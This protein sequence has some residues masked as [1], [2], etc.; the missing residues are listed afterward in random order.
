[1]F[2]LFYLWNPRKKGGKTNLNSGL[3]MYKFFSKLKRAGTS[4]SSLNAPWSPLK[5]NLKKKGRSVPPSRM[6]SGKGKFFLT[7]CTYLYIFTKM[8]SFYNLKTQLMTKT[9]FTVV[10]IHVH[11]HIFFWYE[12][13]EF[14]KK[15]FPC[16]TT[17]S[18][19]GRGGYRGRVR[20]SFHFFWHGQGQL[21][22]AKKM[23]T[24]FF[25]KENHFFMSNIYSPAPRGGRVRASFHFCWR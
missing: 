22:H 3:L 12:N 11:A 20:A 23:F 5:C 18:L 21:A 24:C 9:N 6:K 4:M 13:A 8:E 10:D 2:Y 19:G 16:M 7:S 14:W 25:L 1:M 17:F 15:K